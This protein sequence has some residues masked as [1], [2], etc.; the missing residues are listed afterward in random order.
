M[1]D[2]PEGAELRYQAA[3]DKGR[4]EIQCCDDC[5]RHVFYPRQLCPHCGSAALRW[6]RPGGWGTVYSTT[7]VRLDP[8]D[9]HDVSLIDLDEGVRLMSRVDDLPPGSVRIGQRVR[10]RVAV[11]QGVGVLVFD[12]AEGAR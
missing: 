6:V 9:L 10:A 3:L 2:L 4:F 5:R 7:T 1:D 11:E 12:A 8:Q